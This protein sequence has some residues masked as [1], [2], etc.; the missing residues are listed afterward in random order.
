MAGKEHTFRVR[1]NE[2]HTVSC[3]QLPQ[4][5]GGGIR[6]PGTEVPGME[7]DKSESRRDGTSR[8]TTALL[9][10]STFHRCSS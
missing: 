8:D 2:G 10:S 3:R 1:Q 4:P 9:H 7:R 5:R 6:K